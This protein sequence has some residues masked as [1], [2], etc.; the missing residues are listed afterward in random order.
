MED[1]LQAVGRTMSTSAGFIRLEIGEGPEH[2]IVLRYRVS[3]AKYRIVQPR[4]Q[5]R[6]AFNY[7]K[8][9]IISIF[10]VVAHQEGYPVT[11]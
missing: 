2:I 4:F 10:G 1:R 8:H 3:W 7:A 5:F 6:I 9:H 11:G